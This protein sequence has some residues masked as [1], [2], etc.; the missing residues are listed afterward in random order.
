MKT[1][2]NISKLE[3]LQCTRAYK[4][5]RAFI[6]K[7]KSGFVVYVQ[8]TDAQANPVGE[9]LDPKPHKEIGKALDDLRERELALA[10]N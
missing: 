8:A 3:Q 7:R 5:K 2:I 6:G 1:K 9:A 10:R 4:G